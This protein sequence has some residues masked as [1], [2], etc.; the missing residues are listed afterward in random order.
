[1]RAYLELLR[2]AN[3]VTALADVL[4]GWAIAG[5]GQSAHLPWLLGAT[6]CLYAGGVVFNDVFDAPLDRVERPERP[7]PSGRVTRAAGAALGSVLLLG[8]LVLASQTTL[9]ATVIAAAIVAGVLLYDAWGKHQA[10]VGPLNMG[11]CRGLNLT[12]GMAAVPGAVLAHWPLALIP[13]TYIVAVTAVSRGEVL[14]GNRTAAGIALALLVGALG[15]L[16]AIAVRS[17][18]RAIWA[19]A[20]L[21]FLGW[22]VMPAFWAAYQT[23][24]PQ[25]ARRA[26][27]TGVLSLVLVNA[28]L[29]TAYASMIY[30][31]LIIWIGLAAGWLAR[32]FA[33]T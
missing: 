18:T 3:V 20:V 30:G 13:I 26:V 6:V 7:I 14:G 8:G 19:L 17:D 27:R 32:R 31:L 28:V 15:A 25:A 10:V 2:P 33:V 16:A 24:A 5:L 4:A 12:L 23:P 1:M 29:G 11:L 9:D 22:R 21:V